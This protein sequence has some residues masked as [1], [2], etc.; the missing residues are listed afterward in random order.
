MQESVAIAGTGF[1]GAVHAHAVRAAGG[2]VAG[3][4]A[5][6][7]ERSRAAADRLKAERAYAGAE[8]LL[9]DDDVDVVHVCTPNHLHAELAGRALEAGRSV[10]CEKPLAT[11][12]D[13]AQRLAGLAAGSGLCDAV[14]FAYRYYPTVRE[15][16]ERIAS[17]RSGAVHL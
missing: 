16:R 9:A 17:G 10:V 5:S 12:L 13:E 4:L 2:T 14:P 6:T 8:E 15:A 7:P 11:S 3:V 1:I